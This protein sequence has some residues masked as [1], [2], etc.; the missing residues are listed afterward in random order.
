[1]K[2]LVSLLVVI[3]LLAGLIWYWYANS[4]VWPPDTKTNLEIVVASI[5]V[6]KGETVALTQKWAGDG[7]LTR[8]RHE[9]SSGSIIYAVAD[10]D[11]RKL[12]ACH[13]EH[14]G[15]SKTVTFSMGRKVWRYYYR[16]QNLD[17]G[18]GFPRPAS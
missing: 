4:F 18:D 1:M 14:D 9:L 15:R 6:Q 12:W 3:V 8:V 5:T 13:I 11:L 7:Y 10:P 2:R 16:E 17:L